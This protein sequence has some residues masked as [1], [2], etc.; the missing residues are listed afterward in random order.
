MEDEGWI[1]TAFAVINHKFSH[2][3]PQQNH[4]NAQIYG[5][6]LLVFNNESGDILIFF[7]HITLDDNFRKEQTLRQHCEQTAIYAANSMNKTKF[8]HMAYVAGLLHDMGKATKK[9]NDYLEDAFAGKDVVRGSVNHTFAGV[10]YLLDKYH[11]QTEMPMRKLTAEIITYAIGAHHGLFDCVD[12][13][14]NNGFM[15]R[16]YKDRNE[17]CYDEAVQNFFENVADE[18]IID[19]LFDKSVEEFSAYYKKSALDW[20]KNRDKVFYQISLLARL[21]LSAVIYGDRR[22]TYEFMNCKDP[23]YDMLWHSQKNII[24]KELYLLFRC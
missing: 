1:S 22:D 14:G 13:N 4:T 24:K 19:A 11:E 8:Y 7:A 9:F 17:L 16:L 6:T 21:L 15:Y 23:A 5:I 3:S 18:K 10:I 20:N 12:L 2:L